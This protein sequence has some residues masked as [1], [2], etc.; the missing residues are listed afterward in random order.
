MG[1]L[2]SETREQD[3]SHRTHIRFVLPSCQAQGTTRLR[4]A[5]STRRETR[6]MP[7]TMDLVLPMTTRTTTA[8]RTGPTTTPTPTTAPTTT[9]ELETQTTPTQAEEDSPRARMAR[10]PP[11][12]GRR[13]Y[14]GPS[15]GT[16]HVRLS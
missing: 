4:A 10:R 13:R 9:M 14:P 2:L 7:E 12:E 16:P 15:S 1:A 6:T 11:S 8:T 5:A 3:I